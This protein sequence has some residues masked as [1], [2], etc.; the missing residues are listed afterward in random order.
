MLFSI[1]AHATSD[2]GISLWNLSLESNWIKK[3]K[4]SNWI[5]SC[6]QKSE[7]VHARISH[8][9]KKYKQYKYPAETKLGCVLIKEYCNLSPSY[10]IY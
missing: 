10:Y 6:W 5:S 1:S 8:N 9:I 2:P 3:K 7:S 4:E